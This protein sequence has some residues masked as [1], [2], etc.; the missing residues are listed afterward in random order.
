M[1]TLLVLAGPTAV[2]KLWVAQIAE[3]RVRRSRRRRRSAGPRAAEG[4]IEPGSGGRLVGARPS[5]GVGCAVARFR[6]VS[7]GHWCMGERLQTHARCGG[8][9]APSAT[10]LDVCATRR[11]SGTAARAPSGDRAGVRDRGSSNVRGPRRRRSRALG[12]E[13]RDGRRA[14]S[15]YGCG[16]PSGAA[17]RSRMTA[18][19]SC[20]RDLTRHIRLARA[21]RQVQVRSTSPLISH[22][23][24]G[25]RPERARHRAR[26][27]TAGAR[28]L[29]ARPD[30]VSHRAAAGTPPRR[31]ARIGRCRPCGRRPLCCVRCSAASAR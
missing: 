2:G 13:I 12:C 21:A 22:E 23:T 26:R 5:R 18:V 4:W 31:R 15:R 24:P 1:A 10:A 27:G 25:F 9:R 29:G 14:G 7:R 19:L 6:G 16:D 8:T 28:R 3:P 20:T 17:R 30:R 11:D